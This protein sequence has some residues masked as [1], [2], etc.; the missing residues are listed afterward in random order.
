MALSK[1]GKL[2]FIITLFI[3]LSDGLFVWINFTASQASL[4]SQLTDE[5]AESKATFDLTLNYTMS[6]FTQLATYVAGDQRVQQ[7]FLQGKEA[8]EREGGGAG[9]PRAAE[10]RRQLY[11]LVRPGWEG[12]QE[13]FQ[14]RQLHFHLGPGSTSYL[15]VHK[16]RKFGDNMDTV[17][18]T[19]VD[20]NRRQQPTRGFETGRVYSGIRGVVPVF[21]RKD[22]IDKPVHVGA[23]EAGTSF[24]HLLQI[25]EN[26]TET[27]FAV[28]LTLEHMRANVWPD[29]LDKMLKDKPPIQGYFIEAGNDPD[30]VRR[31]LEGPRWDLQHPRDTVRLVRDNGRT[32]AVNAFPLF[33]Y[34]STQ[35]PELGP[36][37]MVLSWRDVSKPLAAFDRQF[38][39]NIFYAAVAFL[40]LESLLYFGIQRV[41]RGLQRIIDTRTAELA[42]SNDNLSQRNEELV[43]S[44]AELSRTRD[45]LVVSE[46]LASLGGLV[47]GVAHEINTPVGIALTA[48]TH[49][50]DK[51]DNFERKVEADDL[52]RRDL[53]DFL[54]SSRRAGDIVVGNLQ[55]AADLVQSFK[56]VAT[57][58]ATEVIRDFDLAL[59]IDE[60]LLNL[61][62]KLKGTG[63]EVSLDCPAGIMIH[64]YPGALSQVLTNLVVN[65]LEHG[66]EAGSP[67][68]IEILCRPRPENHLRLRY[69]D[70]GRGIP[71]A[72]RGQ[73]FEPFFTT[74]RHAGGTG[75]GLSIVYNLVSGT[76]GGTISLEEVQ[77]HGAGFVIDIPVTRN[78]QHQHSSNSP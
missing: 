29:F 6:S 1:P 34:H 61:Q 7:L 10:L 43:E 77:P 48:S 2:F 52:T 5:M 64:S 22:G 76:L 36:V 63:I 14:A 56:R 26:H 73:V 11:E 19:I 75:L 67:G 72:H 21:A 8:V 59:Y 28:L 60:V 4:L 20:A 30:K 23:L 50:G 58:Q 66:F 51:I 41:T 69:R 39:I 24:P 37:G 18:Y 27:Q 53:D 46:K 45:Q 70:N 32:L 9:G 62:P 35:Q 16:P 31:L 65:S 49:M 38:G 44:M 74:A 40:L 57:D 71:E 55:R 15:R 47:A 13:R 78:Q 12:M 68:R 3:A 17:R 54:V 42:E 33:D 25:V